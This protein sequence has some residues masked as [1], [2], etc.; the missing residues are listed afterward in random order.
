MKQRWW[1]RLTSG[2]FGRPAGGGVERGLGVLLSD[3]HIRR[4]GN[5]RSVHARSPE[6][7]ND[8]AAT[9]I[10]VINT[11]AK[12]DRTA[13][14]KLRGT[15]IELVKAAHRTA[16]YLHLLVMLRDHPQWRIHRRLS[17]P[18]RRREHDG[19]TFDENRASIARWGLLGLEV[20]LMAVEFLFWYSAFTMNLDRRAGWTDHDRLMAV[21]VSL[22]IPAVSIWAAGFA[23]RRAHLWVMDYEGIS[24]RRHSGAVVGLVVFGLVLVAMVLLVLHRFGEAHVTVGSMS[25]PA[26]PMALV[27]AAALITDAAVRTYLTSEIREQYR[28]R[29]AEF[30]KLCA[31]LIDANQRHYTAWLALRSLVQ[32]K[33]DLKVQFE[34]R[35]A[36]LLAQAEAVHGDPHAVRALPEAGTALA[37]PSPSAR[38]AL[39]APDLMSRRLFNEVE[40]LLPPRSLSDMT[41]LL[42]NCHAWDPEALSAELE[43]LWRALHEEEPG[44]DNPENPGK[45]QLK[46]S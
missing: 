42:L 31:K 19:E 36:V 27:F 38:S 5:V 4:K 40:E 37:D 3:A 23:G 34:T 44:A 1:T 30:T 15:M 18:A 24:K 43:R 35:G 29:A 45:P 11:L 8:E 7:Y 39:R 22:F 33:L 41:D 25:V 20:M 21:A 32:Q 12:E 28:K 13:G 2:V 9:V 6:L 16:L 46:V 17:G 14:R 26:W 10:E